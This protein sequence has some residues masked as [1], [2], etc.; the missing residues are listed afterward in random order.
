M[1][2][3]NQPVAFSSAVLEGSAG[4]ISAAIFDQD[5]FSTSMRHFAHVPG[6]LLAA[7]G[8]AGRMAASSHLSGP[9]Q[10]S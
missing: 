2:T 1:T 10:I 8:G 7:I 3:K 5:I 9:E 4:M 6:C